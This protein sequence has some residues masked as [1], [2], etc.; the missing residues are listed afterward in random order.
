MSQSTRREFLGQVGAAAGAAAIARPPARADAAER[1]NIVLILADD[2]GY[3]DLSCYGQRRFRTPNLDRLAAQGA[4]LTS[5]YSGSPVCAPSRCAL[6]TGLHTGHTPIRDN[7][8]MR[9]RGDVWNDP[10]IEGQRPIPAGT[11][12]LAGMLR[13]AGYRTALIGKWGL[14]GPDSEGEPTKMG[15]DESFGYL[16]QRQAHNAYPDHLWHNGR[17]VALDNPTFRAH[18]KFP[19]G[20]D[21]LDPRSYAEYRGRQYAL[22]VMLDR[23][24]DFIRAHRSQPFF[25]HLTP[26]IPHLA[27]QVP[28]D[29]LA[30]YLGKFPETP[31]LG[32]KGYLP[33][34]APRAAYAA[35]IARLDRGVSR[36]LATLADSGL[37]RRTLVIVTSDNGAT[38]ET[39]GYDPAFFQSNAPWRGGKQDLYEG[40]IRVP[41]LARW[42]GKIP[43]GLVR[44]DPSASWDLMATFAQ[45]A[46]SSLL[47]QR[48]SV[49]VPPD[50]VSLWPALSGGGAVTRDHLYWE[51][52]GRQALR[53]GRWKLF[54]DARK[55]VTELYDLQSDPAETRNRASSDPERVTRMMRVMAAA[56]TESER[57]PLLV[58]KR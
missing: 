32:Q 46:G 55:D 49:A 15:F 3:N 27:L 24:D 33:H 20:R 6:L 21:P 48:S 7:D 16:C 29:S 17:R 25:L 34:P 41:F 22:D 40:G 18:Q 38:F 19:E 23:A 1:P 13:S 31:Y 43:A 11:P 58:Q 5:H 12:T 2:L 9:E 36:L 39:G 50:G 30:E 42:P 35:M 56:R 26:T 28:E 45:L 51:F 57:Y 52:Q 54:R 8:E 47:A 14:G 44:D 53:Q 10:S 4:R 37:D